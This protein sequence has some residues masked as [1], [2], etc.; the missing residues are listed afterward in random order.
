VKPICVDQIKIG[1]GAPLALIAGPCIIENQEKTAQIAR[2]LKDL[3]DELA[4]P[5]ILKAS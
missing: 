4:I 1:G 2:Y 3:T 5:L